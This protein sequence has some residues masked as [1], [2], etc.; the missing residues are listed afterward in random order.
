MRASHADRDRVIDTLKAAYVYGLVTKD[1][2]DDRVGHALASR[3]RAEL[4]LITADIPD[5][6][7]TAPPLL[8]PELAKASLP[9]RAKLRPS[10]RAVGTT[11]VLSASLFIV[12]FFAPSQLAELL[13]LG[14]T[15]SAL[16]SLFLAVARALGSRHDKRS[17]GEIPPRGAVGTGLE[18]GQ[19]PQISQPRRQSPADAARSRALRPQPS[20]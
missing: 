9:A 10:D 16:V 13:A 15:G 2:F 20:T 3:S 5:E 17:S 19:L 11:L 1:E 18:T 8:S 12:A 7:P 6:L 14:A 4:A